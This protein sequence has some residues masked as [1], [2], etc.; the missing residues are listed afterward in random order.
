MFLNITCK[1]VL[2]L[3]TIA[4]IIISLSQSISHKTT[5]IIMSIYSYILMQYCQSYL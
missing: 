5:W 3:I 1:N 4:V 2:R